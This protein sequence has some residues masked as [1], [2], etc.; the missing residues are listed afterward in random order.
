MLT[1]LKELKK[2]NH[3]KMLELGRQTGV[4]KAE[5]AKNNIQEQKLNEQMLNKSINLQDPNFLYNMRFISAEY[6]ILR[7]NIK[8]LH[9]SNEFLN[10]KIKQIQ[11]QMNDVNKEKEKYDYLIDV[12]Q[13]KVKKQKTKKQNKL[14]EEFVYANYTNKQSHQKVAKM[15]L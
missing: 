14:I 7:N 8:L 9:S 12:E 6:D 13:N 5:I 11:A 2:I 3:F 15:A 1:Y 10:S 4:F